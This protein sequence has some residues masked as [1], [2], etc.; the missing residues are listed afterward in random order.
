MD[1]RIDEFRPFGFEVVATDITPGARKVAL[2]TRA[3]LEPEQDVGFRRGRLHCQ[4]ILGDAGAV[5]SIG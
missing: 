5:V 4:T 1:N 3:D 2:L